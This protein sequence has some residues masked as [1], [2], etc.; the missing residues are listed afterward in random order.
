MSSAKEEELE[1]IYTV[2]LSRAWIAPRHRRTKRAVN[3]LREYAVKH[4]KSSEIKID[5]GLNEM[6][7][8][9][10]ITAPP[11][12]ITVKMIRD[13]DGVVTISLPKEEKGKQEVRAPEQAEEG[14]N[15][16]VPAAKKQETSPADV[17][18][19]ASQQTSKSGATE[20]APSQA[21]SKESPKLKKKG[22]P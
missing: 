20:S 15:E 22:Q 2:P 7:W 3:I 21:T 11:R 13:E 18:A 12:K 4:M 5:T 17:V 14:E 6:M 16:T 10:G 9:R 19:P 8:V 1:R